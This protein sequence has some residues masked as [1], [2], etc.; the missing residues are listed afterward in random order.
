MLIVFTHTEA[1]L[2]TRTALVTH[3]HERSN[4]FVHQSVPEQ[5]GGAQSALSDQGAQLL[6]LLLA[7]TIPKPRLPLHGPTGPDPRPG[8]TT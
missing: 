4:P 2:K 1:H 3:H 6:A 8:Q 5:P 7:Q